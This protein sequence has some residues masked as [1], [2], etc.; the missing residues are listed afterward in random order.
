MA[1]TTHQS[2][3]INAHETK[4][5]RG[6]LRTGAVVGRIVN[7]GS[8]NSSISGDAALAATIGLMEIERLKLEELQRFVQATAQLQDERAQRQEETAQRTAQR[9][10][11]I[12]LEILRILRRSSVSSV[13]TQFAR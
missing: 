12:L 4:R 8:S 10:E 3:E 9:Q 1:S 5:Q 7:M 6:Q 2:H 13:T 11:E